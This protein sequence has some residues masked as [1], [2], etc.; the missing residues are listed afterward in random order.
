MNIVTQKT[1]KYHRIFWR[2]YIEKTII[3]EYDMLG[4]YEETITSYTLVYKRYNKY[5]VVL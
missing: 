5:G 4:G 1:I 3:F 2:I